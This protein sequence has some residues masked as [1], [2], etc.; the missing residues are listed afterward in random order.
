MSARIAPIIAN[1]YPF[2][3][4]R[5]PGEEAV[6]CIY[7]K[8]KTLHTTTDFSEAGFV[9][10]PFVAKSEKLYL[11]N[12]HCFSFI[13][14]KKAPNATV[15]SSLPLTQ[16]ENFIKKVEAAVKALESQSM[17]KV[18]LSN[19]FNFPYTGDALAVFDRLLEH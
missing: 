14:D 5:L 9:F 10:A 17:E 8:D 18:V 2:V 4:Y 7:Q 11:P 13:P 3:L 16:K 15:A 1:D 19:T 6:H 12:S